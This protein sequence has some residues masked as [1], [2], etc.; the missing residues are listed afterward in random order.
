MMATSSLT[1]SSTV[2][3]VS[4]NPSASKEFRKVTVPLFGQII[5][6]LE[7]MMSEESDE[8]LSLFET[9]DCGSGITERISQNFASFNYEELTDQEWVE[10]M[11]QISRL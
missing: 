11:L 5:E 3:K 1:G 6:V 8:L 4:S 2:A 7:D 9:T 10:R